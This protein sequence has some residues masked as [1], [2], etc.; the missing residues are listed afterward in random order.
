MY[1]SFEQPKNIC[2][3]MLEL[4]VYNLWSPKLNEVKEVH[5]SNIRKQELV[6]I[7]LTGN[8]V[9]FDMDEQPEK[10]LR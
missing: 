7:F 5:F 6:A 4:L 9:A 8:S 2:Y 3:K 1:E 10:R